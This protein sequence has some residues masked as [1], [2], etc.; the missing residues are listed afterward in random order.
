MKYTILVP[1]A[2]VLLACICR[3]NVMTPRTSG[4][5]WRLTYI[6]LASWTGWLAA[7]VLEYGTVH[8]KDAIGVMSLSLYIYLTKAKW[9]AGV[10]DVARQ[11][12]NFSS[13]Y[14]E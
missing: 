14:K 6:L 13:S 5:L 7:D 1:V 10:P 11:K 12:V 8:I 4:V 2:Y 9:I 3:L